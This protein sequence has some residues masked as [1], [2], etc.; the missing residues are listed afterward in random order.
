MKAK[1]D[2]KNPRVAPDTEKGKSRFDLNFTKMNSLRKISAIVIVYFGLVMGFSILNSCSISDSIEP[3]GLIEKQERQELFELFKN[4]MRKVSNE[5]N[6]KS[7][8]KGARL[9][10]VDEAI[11]FEDEI[12]PTALDIFYS[13]GFTTSEILEEFGSLKSPDISLAAQAVVLLEEE[14]DNNRLIYF[15]DE[16]DVYTAGIFGI[17]SSYAQTDTIGGCLAD[18]VGISAVFALID[19]GAQKKMKKK[20]IKKAIRKVVSRSLGVVGGALAVYDFSKCMGWI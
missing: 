12:R 20:A 15:M 8:S 9:T 19:G 13:Y 16:T 11:L 3:V 6:S 14:L 7:S 5:L 10:Q 1:N 4:K 2:L 18:A 17:S